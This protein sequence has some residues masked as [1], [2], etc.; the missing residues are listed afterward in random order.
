MSFNW[1]KRV[2]TMYGLLHYCIRLVAFHYFP[3]F[4]SG[5]STRNRNSHLFIRLP[6]IVSDCMLHK[7]S[8]PPVAMHQHATHK[9]IQPPGTLTNELYRTGVVKWNADGGNYDTE[10]VDNDDCEEGRLDNN[11]MS[12]KVNWPGKIHYD[13]LSTHPRGNSI[14]GHHKPPHGWCHEQAPLQKW[15]VP[16]PL[17]K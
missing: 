5:F 15:P 2:S 4:F 13:S 11:E 7:S 17:T 3:S 9:C 1:P 12:I 14:E 8:K 10:G 6:I 16:S